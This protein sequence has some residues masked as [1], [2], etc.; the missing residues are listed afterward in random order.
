MISRIKDLW[1][2]ITTS[3]ADFAYVAS[4]ERKLLAKD[5]LA[6][7]EAYLRGESMINPYRDKEEW[8]RNYV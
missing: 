1:D 7:H 3:L 5:R 6:D 8:F 4:D 2:D